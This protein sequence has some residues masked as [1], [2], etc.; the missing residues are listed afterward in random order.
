M[1]KT[2]NSSWRRFELQLAEIEAAL[3][4]TSAKIKSPDHLPDV[5]TGEM[6]E[7]DATMR[8]EIGSTSII[9]G[10]ECRKR[11]TPQDVIWVEQ[12]ASKRQ[13]LKLD[14]L[15][16]VSASGF[17]SAFKA[18]ANRMG[19]EYRQISEMKEAALKILKDDIRLTGL[20][21]PKLLRSAAI[22]WG[23]GQQPRG[24][25]A[26][27]FNS[28]LV[29][30]GL[31]MVFGYRYSNDGP[32]SL[33]DFVQQACVA[34]I[35]EL[36]DLRNKVSSLQMQIQFQEPEYYYSVEEFKYPLKE[37]HLDLDIAAGIVP[38]P[39]A[40]ASTY[41]KLDEK[42]GGVVQ[43]EFVQLDENNSSRLTIV[44]TNEKIYS[45]AVFDSSG[46]TG[47]PDGV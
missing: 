15:I 9:V 46:Q 17:T 35:R 33:Q 30:K 8:F 6:R 18:K 31:D 16:A 34:V 22:R 13:S 4:G 11:K 38:V 2:K 36:A 43:T 10:F 32:I 28:E 37:I 14:K 3:S 20:A 21:F 25:A 5:D 1:K 27:H 19:I 41:L 12:L 29:K 42:F 47:N 45:H 24:I 44:F 40:T 39:I 26:A 7:V 23:V